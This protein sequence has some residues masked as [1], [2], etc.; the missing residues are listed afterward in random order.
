MAIIIGV[1]D[2]VTC[3]S[4]VTLLHTLTVTCVCGNPVT[5]VF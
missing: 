3:V 5:S 1:F 4:Y 2:F